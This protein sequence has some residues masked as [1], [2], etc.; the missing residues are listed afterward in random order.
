[1]SS[2]SPPSPLLKEAQGDWSVFK[3]TH[4]HLLYSAWL[5]INKSAPEIIF[6]AGND[7][8]APTVRPPQELTTKEVVG[9]HLDL[10][11]KQTDE[12]IQ[13]KN[14]NDRWTLNR[15]LK[16]DGD[17]NKL[18][19]TFIFNA[20]YS[21]SRNRKWTARLIAP[22]GVGNDFQEFVRDVQ[23]HEQ[24][25]S[26]AAA[27]KY[28]PEFNQKV[29]QAFLEWEEYCQ[30]QKIVAPS[31]EKIKKLALTIL[32][33]LS[34]SPALPSDHLKYELEIE[35]LCRLID[36]QRT[37][38]AIQKLQGE[39]LNI[40]NEKAI[41]PRTI[42][43]AEISV[44]IGE[45]LQREDL[46]DSAPV[47][48]CASQVARFCSRNWGTLPYTPRAQL[49]STLE[50]F[51]HSKHCL[52]ILSGDSGTGKSWA[53]TYWATD[54]L[55]NS[56]RVWL[57]AIHLSKQQTLS[58]A[59]YEAC[60]HLARPA[61]TEQ[62]IFRILHSASKVQGQGPLVLIFDDLEVPTNL[63]AFIAHVEEICKE[64]ESYQ[65]KLIISMRPGIW[66]RLFR[67]TNQIAPYLYEPQT[68]SADTN[69]PKASF[70]LG[71]LNNQELE[72]ILR[73][74][75]PVNT[76]FHDTLRQ[77]IHPKF[78]V[79]RNPYLLNLFINQHSKE[80]LRG[81]VSLATVDSL[82][83]YVIK[84]RMRHI[85]NQ[86][87]YE[88]AEVSA[89]LRDG[90]IPLLWHQRT[91]GVNI[92]SIIDT[93]RPHV[94]D[95]QREALWA[96]RKQDIL[97]VTESID[98]QQAMV[99]WSNTQVGARL[100]AQWLYK[101]YA[102][103]EDILVE[104]APGF[105]DEVLHALL[106]DEI[107][108]PTS[109][110][111]A[112]A[113]TSV[114]R[115]EEWI[116]AAAGGIAQRI[117]EPFPVLAILTAWSSSSGPKIV[118]AM[119]ALA[120]MLPRSRMA[121]DWA[122]KLFLDPSPNVSL[123]GG[124]AMRA[125]F[126]YMSRWV[127]KIVRMRVAW[128]LNSKMGQEWPAD[129][130]SRMFARAIAPMS[131]ISHSAAAQNVNS[132]LVWLDTRAKGITP[133]PWSVS[134]EYRRQID[135]IKGGIAE[136]DASTRLGLITCLTYTDAEKRLAAAVS[137]TQILLKRD[138]QDKEVLAA[139]LTCLR[140]E[141]NEDVL[142]QLLSSLFSQVEFIADEILTILARFTPSQH[143]V[144]GVVLSLL[145]KLAA[146]R[147]E[148]TRALLPP[149]LSS[150]Q[151]PERVILTE[152]FLAA[153][154]HYASV[155]PGDLY[156]KEVFEKHS[157]PD[158]EGV[159]PALRLIAGRNA[160]IAKL[161]L[162]SY[163]VPQL[164][165]A[166]QEQQYVFY[167]GARSSNKGYFYLFMS[168][169]CRRAG[170]PNILRSF[171]AASLVEQLCEAIR[172][173]KNNEAHPVEKPVFSWQWQLANDTVDWLC[174]FIRYL[175]E[176]VGFLSKL[177][178]G[179]PV[180]RACTILLENGSSNRTEIFKYGIRVA[181]EHRTSDLFID[182]RDRFVSMLPRSDERPLP[183]L[184]FI[185]ETA[186]KQPTDLLELLPNFLEQDR[187]I[188]R[189]WHWSFQSSHWRTVLLSRVYRIGFWTA[190]LP[191]RR[192]R[193]VCEQMLAALSGLS[194]SAEA[195]R[196]IQFYRY[197]YQVCNG[198]QTQCPPLTQRTQN[199]PDSL[200]F[201]SEI[202]RRWQNGQEVID[203]KWF[204][205]LFDKRIGWTEDFQHHLVAGNVTTTIRFGYQSP[206]SCYFF[207]EFRLAIAIASQ[208]SLGRDFIPQWLQGWH[209][210]YAALVG[211]TEIDNN[212]DPSDPDIFSKI[213]PSLEA[214]MQENP[215]HV[216][217]PAL[218]AYLGNVL[219][220]AGQWNQAQLVLNQ[221][222]ASP[223]LSDAECASARYDLACAL[224]RTD[225]DGEAQAALSLAI[226][227]LSMPREVMEQDSDFSSIREHRWFQDLLKQ[228]PTHAERRMKKIL[229]ERKYLISVYERRFGS[230]P[231]DIKQKVEAA[232]NLAQLVSWN[233]VF[234]S[235]KPDELL[236]KMYRGNHMVVMMTDPYDR[237]A[238]EE[239][240]KTPSDI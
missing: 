77:L 217:L 163:E 134:L 66:S 181:N 64:A 11:E 207:P 238:P 170:I 20:L 5:L 221:Y 15:I 153:W 9:I 79:L 172:E 140:Q 14:D 141:Q 119:D 23:Q 6:Y 28:Y 142:M 220:R 81:R 157:I 196:R 90:L 114:N 59:V 26:T 214:R 63:S 12:W 187:L 200:D 58:T 76:F 233:G 183:G 189:V 22:K 228:L 50:A 42:T 156:A 158:Y 110:A 211:A 87:G 143:A 48:A 10:T 109:A 43:L 56:I 97:T 102:S 179:W 16:A 126:E 166:L 216:S 35:L 174:E 148:Q 4:Y 54:L 201:S 206:L 72:S 73:A 208:K 159:P 133:A 176:P 210:I 78:S 44:R 69:V 96:L 218:L 47:R 2:T 107:S 67:N 41:T 149:T 55:K 226:K 212:Q 173:Y 235:A 152:V 36:R 8:L 150:I 199:S 128:L 19:P 51:L 164:Y 117:N 52:F 190:P 61:A 138:N 92:K 229:D 213:I 108:L 121:R 209:D 202:M 27:P 147:P 89:A 105:D 112:L 75:I 65:I 231:N 39:L 146:L 94:G 165:K 139:V 144:F 193:D 21:E 124:F 145:S 160:S 198:E 99:A 80:L 49:Q 186:E 1:M 230:I 219:V 168:R 60:K 98:G 84:E 31:K 74:R 101:R 131:Q 162:I 154:W 197:L 203:E 185:D 130:R 68:K 232:Q 129:E 191:L 25:P 184:Q 85:S 136:Y 122:A 167:P 137:L 91:A 118:S 182:D 32:K 30:L 38:Q 178:D 125:A 237:D 46:L 7:L 223:G 113:W 195:E 57:N 111:V 177:P 86:I 29:E 88:I 37:R 205:I 82:L 132:L 161:A 151:P 224:A 194:K 171:H 175:P 169:L 225:Q 104:M 100:T 236:D 103:G 135:V 17:E 180:L 106:R 71:S 115:H 215:A 24:D 93:L 34:D 239:E 70:V 234:S 18:L 3:G 116:S 188:E 53:L 240:G 83:D 33:C 222:L 120:T 227:H 204:H 192:C 127:V 62:E 155:R 95:M 123:V 40:V 13:L 45:T